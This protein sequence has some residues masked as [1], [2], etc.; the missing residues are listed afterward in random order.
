[1]TASDPP[2]ARPTAETAPSATPSPP[3]EQPTADTA[4]VT[5]TTTT[6]SPPAPRSTAPPQPPPPA[7]ATFDLAARRAVHW[8][9]LLG[10]TAVVF[11]ICWLIVAP[12]V[13][14][15]MWAVVLA[16]IFRP[17]H[18]RLL[19]RLRSR[20]VAAAVSCLLVIVTILIPVTLITLAVARDAAA[21]A[22]HLQANRSQLLDPPPDSRLGRALS[23]VDRYVDIDRVASQQYL[24]SRLAALSGTVA[25][26][27]LNLVGGL[28]GAIIQIVL[29]MFALFFLFRDGDDLWAG[30]R[31]AIPLE[32]NELRQ[33]VTRTKDVIR[34]SVYG[35]VVIAVVQGV[36]GT[37]ALWLLGVPSPLLWG[38]VMTVVCL[39][40]MA[41]SFLVWFPAAVYLLAM[42]HPWR[43]LALCAW[44]VLV[45]S[46]IDN[47]LRPILVGNRTH[48]HELV[49][50]FSVLGGLQVFG[51]LGIV[52]GPVIAAMAIALV[53][54]WRR[55]AGTWA[56]TTTAKPATPAS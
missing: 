4:A 27:T 44:G 46:T 49:V 17:V 37:L 36:L 40:P 5:T 35:S 20:G 31:D 28:V 3:P 25:R 48:L 1:M 38:A 41:G 51:M 10:I 6:T 15:L 55:S 33:V 12:F 8:L 21:V 14:V 16:V 52:A 54:I 9:A 2:V 18:N 39:I 11:Y 19:A 34:A 45:I 30:A 7:A 43:A 50:F 32:R 47:V 23:R 13:E 56:A 29:I 53:D 22:A 24:S 26:G 42:G